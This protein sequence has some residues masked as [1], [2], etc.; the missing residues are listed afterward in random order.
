VD[1]LLGDS[2]ARSPE[3]GSA[4]VGV[5]AASTYSLSCLTST[6][7]AVKRPLPSASLDDGALASRKM[8]GALPS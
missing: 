7:S 5:A 4:V 3:G 2:T 1:D 8:P 6:L